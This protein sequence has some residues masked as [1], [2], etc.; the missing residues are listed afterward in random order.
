MSIQL[1]EIVRNSRFIRESFSLIL[2]IAYSDSLTLLSGEEGTEKI[3]IA[4]L[5]HALSDRDKSAFV[6]LDCRSPLYSNSN[7]SREDRYETKFEDSW[8]SL[9]HQ[10]SGGSV[11]IDGID[12]LNRRGQFYL[13]SILEKEQVQLRRR[14]ALN[15]PTI[16]F[17]LGGSDDLEAR[18]RDGR[19][20]PELYYTMMVVE[21][22]IPP[23]RERRDD[24]IPLAR[25][26]LNSSPG[27]IGSA[28]DSKAKS[29]LVSYDWPGNFYELKVVLNQALGDLQDGWI[30][31]RSLIEKIG[32][33]FRSP[34]LTMSMS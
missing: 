4:K 15:L 13:K 7:H 34:E 12:F 32:L 9:R 30:T 2:K 17:I 23:L 20:L 24:I 27:G 33:N 8:S 26:I 21:I 3:Y 18:V 31:G 29:V 6:R 11:Y 19:F 14:E 28:F 1:N 22:E 10:V 5:I 16:R 25:L